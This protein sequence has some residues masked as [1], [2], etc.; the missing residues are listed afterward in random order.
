MEP[1]I[2]IPVARVPA[3]A[4]GPVARGGRTALDVFDDRVASSGSRT[5]L[6]RKVGTRWEASSWDDWDRVSREIAAGLCSIGVDSGDAIAVLS[7][8]RAEWVECDVGILRAGAITV[9]IYPSST[10]EQCEYIIADA[11]CRIVLVEGPHQLEKLYQPNVVSGLVGIDRIVYLSEHALLEVPDHA[12]RT[13]VTL[14]EVLP[15]SAERRRLI[16]L[17]Q[18]MADGRAWLDEHPDALAARKR[19]IDPEQAATYI[20]TSGTTG[21]PKGVILTHANLSFECDAVK[22]LLEMGPDDEQLLFLPL[23]HSF[24]KVLVWSAISVGCV[25]AFAESIARLVPNMQEV[26]PTFVGAVPRV[27]E[28]A[29]V[30]LQAGFEQKRK[31]L[32][33][34]WIV[35]WAL[36]KGRQR[37]HLLLEGKPARGLGFRLADMLVFDKVRDTFGGRLRFFISGGAP[38]APEI[39]SFFHAAGVLILEGYGLTETFAASHVNRPD[40]YRFGTVGLP[41]PGVEVKIADDGEILLRGG[42]IMKGYLGRPEATAEA[43]EPDGWLHTGDIGAVEED[44]KLRITDRKKDLIVTAGG[45]NVAPQNIEG[46]LKAACPYLSQVMVYGDKRKYLVALLTLAEENLLPWAAEHDLGGKS[47]AELSVE[48]AVEALIDG[49]VQ[50]LNGTLASYESIKK[51]KILPHDFGQESGELTPTLKVKRKYC[52]QKYWEILSSLY[53]AE[54]QSSL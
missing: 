11:G 12:G 50:A 45:K 20:Y 43:L 4:P 16:S 27:Y 1:R 26:H 49:Y 28:K 51:Y 54:D 2:E 18:L 23:A 21:P 6:R 19:A 33:T 10:P 34:R 40:D 3:A 7:N 53:P 35:N 24:A 39:A 38:L 22:D 5:A 14:E 44:G 52:T 32:L 17:E 8:T 41:I 15:P 46:S 31:H 48:P 42:N 13:E 29:Y 9:P 36:K 30:K 47:L 37:S 25:T